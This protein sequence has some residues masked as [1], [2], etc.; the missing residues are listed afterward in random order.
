M[1]QLQR[2]GVSRLREPAADREGERDAEDGR[3]SVCEC[4]REW[5]RAR[6]SVTAVHAPVCSRVCVHAVR[7][8][9]GERKREALTGYSSEGAHAHERHARTHASMS[10]TRSRRF[11]SIR[12]RHTRAESHG[13]PREN[14]GEG[15][16]QLTSKVISALAKTRALGIIEHFPIFE[17]FKK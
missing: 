13:Y 7:M 11:G 6:A 2:V 4:V 1:L 5:V 15:N 10:A 12:T 8:R 14:R 9:D 16:W 17:I 3:A